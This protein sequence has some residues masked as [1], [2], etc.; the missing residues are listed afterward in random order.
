[1]LV[2]IGA[3]TP[4]RPAAAG[5]PASGVESVLT[6]SGKVGPRGLLVSKE[7]RRSCPSRQCTLPAPEH[8]RSLLACNID[9][10]YNDSKRIDLCFKGGGSGTSHRDPR[11]GV[12]VQ[13]TL[14]CFHEASIFEDREIPRRVAGQPSPSSSPCPQARSAHPARVRTCDLLVGERPVGAKRAKPARSAS[15]RSA[16]GW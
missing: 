5:T 1:M 8:L 11:F 12:L 13:P 16:T 6:P 15:P 14:G 9:T 4:D 3:G 10:Q 2:L 7:R